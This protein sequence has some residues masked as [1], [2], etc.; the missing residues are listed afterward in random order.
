MRLGDEDSEDDLKL[1][2]GIGVPSACTI[3]IIAGNKFWGNQCQSEKT[4]LK[5]KSDSVRLTLT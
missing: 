1:V 3:V 2:T 4:P 5:S